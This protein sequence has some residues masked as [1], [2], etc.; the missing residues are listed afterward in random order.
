MGAF[1]VNVCLIACVVALSGCWSMA[2]YRAA[3]EGKVAVAPDQYKVDPDTYPP[4]QVKERF[5]PPP[6]LLFPD[7]ETF[8]A[9]QEVSRKNWHPDRTLH[10]P[11]LS[12][13]VYWRQRDEAFYYDLLGTSQPVDILPEDVWRV[14]HRVGNRLL[15]Y[16][17]EYQER[18]CRRVTERAKRFGGMGSAGRIDRNGKCHSLPALYH[19]FINE[20]GEVVGGWT[21]LNNRNHRVVLEPESPNDGWGPQPL[22]V[23]GR[24][25]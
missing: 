15:I 21:L 5:T 12:D 8:I 24:G 22:F 7:K 9:Q 4:F 23:K 3:A 10:L 19:I 18:E 17:E 2:D 6:T 20:E 16:S 11:P 14:T 25:R 1:A 13:K